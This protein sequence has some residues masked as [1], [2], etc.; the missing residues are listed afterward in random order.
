M[1]PKQ[2]HQL[3]KFIKELE[4]IRGRHTELVS[5][6]I[7]A[8]Y[9]LNKIITHLEQE[10]GTATNIKDAR[11]RKNVIDS[12]EKAIRHL[13]L[14]KKN[15][16]NGLAIFAGNASDTEG[17]IDIKVWS[18]EPPEPFTTRLYRC[19]QTFV[20]DS[21]RA[22]LD[23]DV[24]YGLIVMDNRDAT[25]GLLKGTLIEVLARKTSA[26]PGK[27]KAGGQ[28]LVPTSLVQLSTG[29]IVEIQEIHNP[30]PV[31]SANFSS[32][33]FVDSPVVDTWRTKKKVLYYITTKFPRTVIESSENHGFFTWGNTIQE[34]QAKD[35]QEGEYLLMPER[36]DVKGELQALHA[37][38]YYNSYILS[39]EG[40]NLITTQR[41]SFRLFQ[42]ELAKNIGVTQTEISVVELGKQAIRL[43]LLQKLCKALFIDGDSFIRLYCT[44]KSMLTLPSILDERLAQLLG[45][46]AGDGSFEVERLSFHD[47]DQH[48]ITVY[49]ILAKQLFQCNISLTFREKKGYWILRLYGKPLVRL[50]KKEFPELK[51]YSDTTIP[52]KILKSENSVLASFLKG[53]FDAEGYVNPKRKSIGLSI[54]NKKLAQQLQ[55]SLLRFGILASLYEYNN[56]KNPYSKEMRYTLSISEKESLTSFF[57]SIGFTSLPKKEKLIKLLKTKSSV[58]YMRRIAVSGENI[59]NILEQ[60]GM[61]IKDFPKITN[62]F[63]NERMMSKSVFLTSL[64]SCIKD[65][66]LLEKIK[67][68]LQYNLLPVK[69]AHIERIEQSTHF[70]D[71]AVKNQN[72]IA[73]GILVHNSAPRFA[74][75]REEAIHDFYKRVGESANKEFFHKKE[76]KGLLIGGPGPSKSDFVD[77][78]Y[79][80]AELK[81][82]VLGIKDLTYTEESG[83]H[84]LVDKSRDLL[85][86]EHITHEKEVVEKFLE[87]LGKNSEKAA[88]GKE[89]VDKAL[90]YG[91]VQILL[92]SESLSDEEIEAYEEKALETDA[93]VEIIS[94]ETREG[95]QLRDLGKIG[96][97][98][99]FALQ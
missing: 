66:T 61:K 12:L 10:Q 98:L 67:P 36:V 11:T 74:R 46:F 53:I 69:I 52:Q 94:V 39:E 50:L 72:F 88:Y 31:K 26:V 14:F 2:K 5:V 4:S 49:T 64:L 37:Q 44:P 78:N 95:I 30:H 22:M 15:P 38:A 3:R 35:L 1:T 40:R 59:R 8:G 24:M 70:V 58:S 17:K 23:T 84:D 27:I 89:Q 42:K 63:R 97:I 86:Q 20:L 43:D 25:I 47:Q 33:T 54:N 28:C 13:R 68:V 16:E 62:F 87:T 85:L 92:L 80:H 96:A 83:L 41:K 90:S 45:Y 6:Y 91:A 9:D 18:I 93:T 57:T 77:G 56:R 71:I 75:L 48:M 76:L 82:K 81:Q 99:R 19:D 34:K 55:M 73:N 32:F 65:K 51:Y 21:L 7:P 29:E 79:L 60:H